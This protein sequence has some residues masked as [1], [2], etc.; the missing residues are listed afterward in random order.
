MSDHYSEQAYFYAN[1][2]TLEGKSIEIDKHEHPLEAGTWL[3]SP[4]FKG[5]ILSLKEVKF[6]KEDI[7][8]KYI[9]SFLKTYLSLG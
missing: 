1:A 5:A 9:R 6:S 7:L 2:Y 4:D 8:R 3:N